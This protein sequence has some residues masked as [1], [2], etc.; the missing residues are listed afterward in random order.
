MDN[1]Q[2]G[3]CKECSDLMLTQEVD[4]CR[5]CGKDMNASYNRC[6]KC[7]VLQNKCCYCNGEL[8]KPEPKK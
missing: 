1:F 2:S 4:Y 6:H 5:H 7:A 3:L 8:K